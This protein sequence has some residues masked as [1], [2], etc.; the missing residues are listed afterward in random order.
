MAHRLRPLGVALL[1]LFSSAT[2]A[3][4]YGNWV[5]A[6]LILISFVDWFLLTL[7]TQYVKSKTEKL[8]GNMGGTSS[9]I[10]YL[11]GTLAAYGLNT[12]PDGVVYIIILAALCYIAGLSGTISAIRLFPERTPN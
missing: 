1:L 3:Q 4:Y 9:S 5:P 12:N 11:T 10:T 8:A 2:Y 6:G 7:Y